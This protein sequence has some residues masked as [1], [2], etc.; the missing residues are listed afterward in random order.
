MTIESS[1]VAAGDTILAADYNKLRNDLLE[2]HDHS[3]GQG[4]TPDHKDLTETGDMSGMG[5]RHEDLDVH[6]VGGGPGPNSIDSPGG[7]MGVHGLASSAYV[8]GSMGKTT[9][10][11]YTAKQ[12]VI[13]CG[14]QAWDT[15]QYGTKNVTFG[16]G[17]FSAVPHVVVSPY[18]GAPGI[19]EALSLAIKG[20]YTT[21]FA[22]MNTS[23][24]IDG[25][26]WI[27]IGE[28]A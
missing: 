9:S 2:N 19:S 21:W 23:F 1:K 4:G 17:G 18:K 27:A 5:H 6:L 15:T 16:G 12:L 14:Y 7:D 28:K 22:V 25:F 26:Y 20:V 10:G 11:S 13:Q 3:A 8:A 24:T